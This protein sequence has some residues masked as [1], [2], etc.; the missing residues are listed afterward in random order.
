LKEN[1]VCALAPELKVFTVVDFV[2]SHQRTPLL[3]VRRERPPVYAVVVVC[4]GAAGLLL[5]HT[6]SDGLVLGAKG[7]TQLAFQHVKQRRRLFR[8]QYP[9]GN[10]AVNQRFNRQLV[11]RQRRRRLRHRRVGCHIYRLYQLGGDGSAALLNEQLHL[12]VAAQHLHVQVRRVGEQH[13]I[14]VLVQHIEEHVAR[15]LCV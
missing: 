1:A 13:V 12:L 2:S 4:H 11:H 10:G 9:R 3:R 7:H 14:E 8:Q 15:L 6:Q 5:I